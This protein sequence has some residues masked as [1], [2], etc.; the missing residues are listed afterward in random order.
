MALIQSDPDHV[1]SEVSSTDLEQIRKWNETVPATVEACVHHLVEEQVHDHPDDEAVCSREGSLTYRELDTYAN[2]LAR[3]L[4]LQNVKPDDLVP[5]RLEKSMWTVVAMLGVLK[6]GA[7]FV[8]MPFSPVQRIVAILS[9]INHTVILTSPQQAKIFQDM[10][11]HV[12][13]MEK[14]L[15][16]MAEADNVEPLRVGMTA[17]NLAYVL[18]TSGSTGTPKVSGW[19][20][21]IQNRYE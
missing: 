9:L 14:G 13:I 21:R 11:E 3:R 19:N 10:N 8:P 2:K 5:V 4:V 15:F 17:S 20:L 7:A 12:M 18:F 1:V 6:I 16:D